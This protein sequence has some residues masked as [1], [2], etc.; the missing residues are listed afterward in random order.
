MNR[1]SLALNK[2]PL[3]EEPGRSDWEEQFDDKA[4]LAMIL[5][6]SF[7]GNHFRGDRDIMAIME[8][9]MHLNSDQLKKIFRHIYH[10]DYDGSVFDS[11]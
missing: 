1:F 3:F 2:V 5:A 7:H 4:V 11:R 9:L 10:K 6:R 8:E